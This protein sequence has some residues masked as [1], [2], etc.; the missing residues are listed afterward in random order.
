M[1]VLELNRILGRTLE[2]FS[3]VPG[4]SIEN[5]SSSQGRVVVELNFRS[6]PMMLVAS[7][8]S[9]PMSRGKGNKKTYG[10]YVVLDEGYGDWVKGDNENECVTYLIA[11]AR[12]RE[13]LIHGL[14]FSE[15]TFSNQ[16]F[17]E[18]LKLENIRDEILIRSNLK[19]L[20]NY[21]FFHPDG[22]PAFSL[23]SDESRIMGKINETSFSITSTSA[24]ETTAAIF[25]FTDGYSR[26]S[27]E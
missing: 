6:L 2:I 17:I 13:A 25:G 9:L 27:D 10:A 18:S 11:W 24:G 12:G 14:K 21:D 22:H 5:V 4:V 16:V 8:E 23:Q 1:E 3:T 19:E 15:L 26:I 20:N 7:E